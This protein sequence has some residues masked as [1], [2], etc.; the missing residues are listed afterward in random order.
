MPR[1]SSWKHSNSSNPRT[2]SSSTFT[3]HRAFPRS[4][5]SLYTEAFYYVTLDKGTRYPC[6]QGDLDATGG[7]NRRT[8]F[9]EANHNDRSRW[10]AHRNHG[11]FVDTKAAVREVFDHNDLDR[12]P[13]AAELEAIDRF[14][15][16]LEIAAKESWGPD[17]VI[18]AFCDLDEIFF[19]GRLR[20]HVLLAW[21]SKDARN[22]RILGCT[23]YL[24]KGKCVIQLYASTIFL[25][26]GNDSYS[27]S[28]FV[29]MWMTLVHE[30]V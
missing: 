26:P 20:G 28:Y 4:P 24:G 6:T 12:T 29:R 15:S 23:R 17:L 30:M 18:K 13:S 25:E 19:G 2:G 21:G 8:V 7:M 14:Y 27:R 16:G 5:T 10:F 9:N 22:S 1:K 11:P 3:N